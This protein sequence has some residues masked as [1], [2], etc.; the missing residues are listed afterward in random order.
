MVKDQQIRRFS[1]PS[2]F[3]IRPWIVPTVVLAALAAITGIVAG[4][5]FASGSGSVPTPDSAVRQFMSHYVTSGGRVVR[6]DQG[7]DTVSEGQAYGMLISAATAN[8]RVFNQIWAWTQKNLLEPDGLLAWRWAGGKVASLEPAADADVGTVAALVLASKRFDDLNLLSQA[9][10]MAAA[11]ATHE[12]MATRAGPTLAAGPWALS[13]RTV[14][15][16]YLALPEL[17]ELAQTLGPP[18]PALTVTAST[19]LQQLVSSGHLPP[20][21]ARIQRGSNI[22]P[23]SPP[24]SPRRTATYGFDAARAPI[25]MALS[26]RA[27]DRAAAAGMVP[28]LQRGH[29][30]V[31]LGLN[32]DPAP[33]VKHPVGLLALAAAT[34][35]AGDHRGGWDSVSAAWKDNLH[36][37]TY[38]GTAWLALTVLGL[39][40]MLKLC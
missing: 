1:T 31:E 13:T 3:D 22:E 33:G 8:R 37:P 4:G 18:W 16:S 40:G 19:E 23:T 38:Y 6:T 7:S 27:G 11:V 34:Y 30:M 35:A 28:G 24:G 26:C 32:G 5:W 20:D 14:N 36:H 10:T 25:W 39:D 2:G 21:W 15:P 12:V 9:R 17:S 29:G